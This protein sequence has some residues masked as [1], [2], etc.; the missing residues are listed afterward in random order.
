MVIR[1]NGTLGTLTSVPKC[2]LT[3]APCSAA[4]AA[5]T[6]ASIRSSKSMTSSTPVI[7]ASSASTP[8]NSV[9]CRAVNDG[10]A[11]NT[12]P[13]SKTRSMPAAIAICL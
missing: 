9:A 6:C 11:R 12:G 1:G 3:T 7:Q 8:V 2:S 13:I 5:R 10:S 4:T